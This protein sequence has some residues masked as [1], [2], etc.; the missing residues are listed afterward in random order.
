MGHTRALL[1]LAARVQAGAAARMLQGLSVRDTEQLVHHLKSRRGA[2][3]A[4]RASAAD[5][6]R[7]AEEF[8][9][10]ALGE[11]RYR[12]EVGRGRR[13]SFRIRARSARPGFSPASSSV[14]ACL[15]PAVSQQRT[16][17][18]ATHRQPN[19]R[20]TARIARAVRPPG[21]TRQ[22]AA[23]V[24][25]AWNFELSGRLD[26]ERLTTVVHEHRKRWHRVPIR[27]R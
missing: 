24:M 6:A 16:L 22:P 25:S 21:R 14:M 1:G 15:L 12:G 8:V 2:G 26:V 19:R 20:K 23:S 5:V 3:R 10:N 27:A 13:L 9:R 7:L 11:S 18:A 17:L 4:R